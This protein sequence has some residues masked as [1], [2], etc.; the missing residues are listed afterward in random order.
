MVLRGGARRLQ[1]ASMPSHPKV[2]ALGV[3][4]T[5]GLSPEAS[6]LF[7]PFYIQ[8][9][10]MGMGCLYRS[11]CRSGGRLGSMRTAGVFSF[12]L[13]SLPPESDRSQLPEDRSVLPSLTTDGRR[14]RAHLFKLSLCP[15]ISPPFARFA[16]PERSSV[17]GFASPK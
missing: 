16:A 7:G 3:Q 13:R 9:R 8:A 2:P 10:G 12:S 6:R 17:R 15:M 1:I 14:T 4:D 11:I 5:G